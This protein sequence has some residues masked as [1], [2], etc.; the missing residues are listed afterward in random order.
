MKIWRNV[1][2]AAIYHT[3]GLY[4]SSSLNIT[5]AVLPDFVLSER[6]WITFIT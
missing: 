5:Q 1:V 2:I 4:G 6:K 3:L